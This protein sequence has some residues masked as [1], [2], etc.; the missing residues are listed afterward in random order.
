MVFHALNQEQITEIVDL[1][2][3]K[4]RERLAEHGLDLRLTDAA[5]D[6]LAEKGYDPNLG[7]R[8]LR[9]VIQT[10]VEDALSE[11]VLAGRFGEG[12]A[13]RGRPGGWRV[14][15]PPGT[16]AEDDA[17]RQRS[18]TAKRLQALEAVLN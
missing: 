13:V 3:D 2:I 10:E 7:A 6:Y 12:D 9:R 16:D 14:G 18:R 5:R 8:P 1:E 17:R 4:V 11:G 15:V